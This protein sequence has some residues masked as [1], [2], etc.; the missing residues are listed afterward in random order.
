MEME[1][2]SHRTPGANHG[3][4]ACGLREARSWRL[5]GVPSGRLYSEAMQGVF[6]DMTTTIAIRSCPRCQ[7]GMISRYDEDPSCIACGHVTYTTP[8]PAGTPQ[9]RRRAKRRGFR[10]HY[11]GDRRNLAHLTV[12]VEPDNDSHYYQIR[13]PFDGAVARGANM[14]AYIGKNGQSN[15]GAY[16][17]RER[18]VIHIQRDDTGA[19]ISWS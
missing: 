12:F 7:G 6:D 4:T 19:P 8:S 5:A 15:G 17:C 11:Q 13:C 3:E 2:P 18:H 9:E 1:Y 16:I 10:I 14:G